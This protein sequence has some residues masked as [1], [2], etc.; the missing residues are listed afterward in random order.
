MAEQSGIKIICK[1]R[2]AFFDFEI[3]DT[4]EAGISL[5]GSEVKSLRNGKANLGDSYAKYKN[6]ELYL[7]DAHIS[8]YSQSNRENHDPLRERKLLMHK[9]ELRKLF[10]KVAERGYSL[11]PLKLYFKSGKVK[12]DLALARGK[13][14][15]DKRES[16]KKKDQRR[17]ME[18][19]QKYSRR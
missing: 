9:R 18:R 10:G 12:V 17:E 5:L 6:G 13:K 8:P 15:Y 14:N 4:Y 1:N 11:I 16:I 2:K 19:L 7:V 3:E